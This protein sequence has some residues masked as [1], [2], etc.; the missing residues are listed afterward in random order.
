METSHRERG[1]AGAGLPVDTAA[2][3][4]TFAAPE[5]RTGPLA[6]LSQG[7]GV[8]GRGRATRDGPDEQL[9]TMASDVR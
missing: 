8:G 5:T 4:A 7:F 1:G 6:W 2:P 3:V 9:T